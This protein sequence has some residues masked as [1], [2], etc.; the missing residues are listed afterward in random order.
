MMER[1][2]QSMAVK[3]RDFMS[4]NPP[5][6]PYGGTLRDALEIMVANDRSSV[7]VMDDD[8]VVGVIGAEDVGRLVAKGVDL[9]AAWVRDFVAACLLTGNQPCV[10][11]RDDDTVLNAL[12][13]MDNWAATQIV[14]ANEKNKV[15]GTLSVLD[16]LKGWMKEVSTARSGA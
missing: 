4:P 7:L 11:I 9:K 2:E 8:N 15:V 16:A 13:V 10:Q 1:S 3:V 5:S 14:V 12:K 6:V